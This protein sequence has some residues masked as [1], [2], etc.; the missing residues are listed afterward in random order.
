MISIKHLEI[1]DPELEKVVGW[2]NDSWVMRFSEQRHSAH[3]VY[4]QRKY[5]RD[6]TAVSGAYFSISNGTKMI[7][8][9]SIIPDKNNNV[10]QVGILI[11]DKSEQGKGHGIVAWSKVCD[12]CFDDGFR[13]VEAGCMATNHA[14]I[15]IFQKYG[16][17]MEGYIRGHFL[18]DGEEVAEVRYGKFNETV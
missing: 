12:F 2:L 9:A 6:L 1:T 3:S 17:E 10:A 18:V 7:G 16:M 4:T 14:M 13:K 15:A 11:G 8:T 5:M